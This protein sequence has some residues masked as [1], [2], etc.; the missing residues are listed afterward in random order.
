[1]A[2]GQLAIHLWEEFEEAGESPGTLASKCYVWRPHYFPPFEEQKPASGLI[3]S[4][5]EVPSSSLF[6]M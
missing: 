4:K 3:L 5:M 6:T 2:M 1:M